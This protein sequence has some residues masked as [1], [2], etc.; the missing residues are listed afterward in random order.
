MRRDEQPTPSERQQY[1]DDF[2]HHSRAE[3]QRWQEVLRQRFPG[4]IA[5]VI[6]CYDRLLLQGTIPGICFA[7]GMEKFLRDRQIELRDFA[8]WAQPLAEKIKN[9]AEALAAEAGIQIEYLRKKIRKEDRV[10]EILAQRGEQPGLICIFSALERCDTY[11]IQKGERWSLRP[12]SGKCLHYYFYFI[13]P[14]W[15][16]GFVRLPTWARFE[17]R[18]TSTATVGWPTS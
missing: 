15:G 3:K 4:V 16:L 13:D 12:D 17:C 8:Q 10:Q 14:Q 1:G 7:G 5:G 2:H 6:S 9:H 18:F 11:R